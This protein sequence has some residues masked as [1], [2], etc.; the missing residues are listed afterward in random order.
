M[1]RSSNKSWKIHTTMF[2]F[3]FSAAS[4]LCLTGASL[5]IGWRQCPGSGRWSRRGAAD[6]G[7]SS[8]RCW[9]SSYK[10][11]GDRRFSK[12]GMFL[13][14]LWPEGHRHTSWTLRRRGGDPVQTGAFL[15]QELSG[16]SLWLSV[17]GDHGL[18]ET[19]HTAR[20]M[21]RTWQLEFIH[22]GNQPSQ[23]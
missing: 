7:E 20:T 15:R 5:G 11:R 12:T 14:E 6:T 9:N 16:L 17:H 18:P 3:L 22:C 10:L 13:H 2:C 4:P 1:F 23:N 19:N 8:R 21:S